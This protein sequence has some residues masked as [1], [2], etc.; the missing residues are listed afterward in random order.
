MPTFDFPLLGSAGNALW[1]EQVAPEKQGRVFAARGLVTQVVSAIA[2]L[3]AGPLADR[4]SNP[5]CCQG[6]LV[7]TV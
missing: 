7:P 3:I 6:Q 2:A 1:M 5:R 4:G